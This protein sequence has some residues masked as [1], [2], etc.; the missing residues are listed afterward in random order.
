MARLIRDF[1]IGLFVIFLLA[2]SAFLA[3]IMC[4][5]A[6]APYFLAHEAG[7]FGMN[8]NDGMPKGMAVFKCAVVGVWITM[9]GNG[10]QKLDWKSLSAG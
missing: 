9:L 7:W 3:L 1:Q 4:A 6:A 10:A 8:P 5:V 2:A